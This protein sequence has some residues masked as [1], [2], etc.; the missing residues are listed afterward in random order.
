MGMSQEVLAYKDF[1]PRD[2][3]EQLEFLMA[4]EKIKFGLVKY[5]KIWK[6]FYKNEHEFY[7]QAA[8]FVDKMPDSQVEE[9]LGDT[10]IEIRKQM[11]DT[12]KKAKI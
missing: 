6:H 9:I 5:K 12:L 2:V 11:A 10:G 3:N 8:R 4:E 7:I 1:S